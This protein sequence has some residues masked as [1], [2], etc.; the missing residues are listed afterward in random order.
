METKYY[1]I[2][3]LGSKRKVNE[4]SLL[5]FEPQD[6]KQLLEKGCIYIVADGVGGLNKGDVA[7]KTVIETVKTE[8]YNFASGDVKESLKFA[9]NKAN[10]LLIGM[11]V[12][13]E[14]LAS[15]VVCAVI[16]DNIAYI[17]NV[18]D[19]RAYLFRN[20]KLIRKTNDHSFVGERMRMG[21]LTEEEARV[22]PRSNIILR[23]VGDTEDL[24][25]DFFEVA[26][27]KN[28]KL[29]LCTD[30]LWGEMPHKILEETLN[31]KTE[32][33]LENLKN[34]ENV[35]RLKNPNVV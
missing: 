16:K 29:L 26:L 20:R 25:I 17:A 10:T 3:D 32:A 14:K 21:E 15:T 30:G 5:A 18:G 35:E 7:S 19:S 27:E 6:E 9:I 31:T 8:Y 1:S 4:D 34:I 28:D 2:L 13:D 24:E 12:E 11:R 23:C 22:H 33:T